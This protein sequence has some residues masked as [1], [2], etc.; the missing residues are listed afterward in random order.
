[1]T[2]HS[3]QSPDVIVS[4]RIVSCYQEEGIADVNEMIQSERPQP[5]RRLREVLSELGTACSRYLTL[6]QSRS[7]ATTGRTRLDIER[8]KMC[9]REIVRLFAMHLFIITVGICVKPSSIIISN[10]FYERRLA[11]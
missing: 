2:V 4:Y 5:D 8:L 10:D 7:G 3:V 11:Q 1:M 6:N 9:Q